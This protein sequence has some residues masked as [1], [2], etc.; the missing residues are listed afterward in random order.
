MVVLPARTEKLPPLPNEV[1]LKPTTGIGGGAS[2]GGA[3]SLV[4]GGGVGARS[5]ALTSLGTGFGLAFGTGL[6]SGFGSG[7]GGGGSTSTGSG[8]SM[9]VISTVVRFFLVSLTAGAVESSAAWTESERN[10]LTLY[11][12]TSQCS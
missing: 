10:K 5:S 2:L 1:P 8:G 9:M 11:V 6:G 7:G 4:D 3:A 12:M